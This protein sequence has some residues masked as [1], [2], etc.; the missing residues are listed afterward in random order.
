MK[1]MLLWI[2]AVLF[3]VSCTL[4]GA[5]AFVGYRVSVSN[6][7]YAVTVL[8]PEGE[9]EPVHAQLFTDVYFETYPKMREVFG[10]TDTMEVTVYFQ[11]DSENIA[12]ASEQCIYVSMEYMDAHPADFNLLVHE[13]FHV[14]QNG[15]VGDD[16][17]IPAL[18]EGM[19]NYARAHYASRQDET[20]FLSTWQEGQSYMDS[21]AVTGGF[22]H[23]IA[24]R[25]GE[26]VLIRLNRTLHEGWYTADVWQNYT[27]HTVDELWAEYAQ[28]GR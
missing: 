12:Y 25:Y 9:E 27:G 3:V 5:E 24:Q 2:L 8:W 13:L 20:W 22:L 10:T 19:A 16:P 7:P 18:T 14:V 23:W 26:S 28:S 11:H 17:I 4:A 6:S 1:K 21:Y 15:Y